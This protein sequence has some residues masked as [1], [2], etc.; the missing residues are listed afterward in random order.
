MELPVRRFVAFAACAAFVCS[1]PKA[2]AQK[3]PDLRSAAS[4]AVLG[5]SVSNTG[6][7]VITGNLAASPGAITGE[8]P[9]VKLG[10]VRNDL[11]AQ[12]QRDLTA[13]HDDLDARSCT[14]T[15]TDLRDRRLSPGVYCLAPGTVLSGPLILDAGGDANAVW[16]FKAG[17]TLATAPD[18]SVRMIDGGNDSN[19]FWQTGSAIVA[20]KTTFVG[21]I[22]A[23]GG[24]TLGDAANVSGRVLARGPVVLSGNFVSLCC[25]RIT[26]LPPAKL[27][28]TVGEE[29]RQKIEATGGVGDFT[30]AVK[31]GPPGMKFVG[32]V[33][34]WTTEPGTVPVTVEATD[35]SGCEGV[36]SFELVIAPCLRIV[37]L[38]PLSPA[39]VCEPYS[40]TF[41]GEC[42]TTPYTCS[43]SGS[44]PGLSFSDCTLSGTPTTKG[45]FPFTVTV[46]DKHASVSQSYALTAGC[47]PPI[48]IAPDTLPNG[49]VGVLYTAVITR[50]AGTL[51]VVDKSKLPPG[52]KATVLDNGDLVVSGVPLNEGGYSFDVTAALCDACASTKSYTITI[53]CPVI[54]LHPS[55]VPATP[56][57]AYPLPPATMDRPY[58][59]TITA[60]TL[61]ATAL[62][63]KFTV[64]GK[65]TW[66]TQLPIDS[67]TL[68]GTP[69][70]RGIYPFTVTA[71]FDGSACSASQAYSIEVICPEITVLPTLP[72]GVVGLPPYNE[73]ISAGGSL[74][75]PYTFVEID[76]P[77]NPSM[78]PPGLTLASDGKVTGMPL[79]PGDY[80]FRVRATDQA[81]CSGDGTVTLHINAVAPGGAI[82]ALSHSAMLVLSLVLAV[83]GFVVI[84]RTH[85]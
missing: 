22:L 43:I 47:P 76:V 57:V 16:I 50:S 42:G 7:T 54:T 56:A 46:T 75:T 48:T 78:L 32:D 41:K 72:S 85:V 79:A 49:L 70:T 29:Y 3:A 83:V 1:A 69:D 31:T 84:R 34:T 5:G 52:L 38:P 13:A 21:N 20:A 14:E 6:P 65:P 80:S 64:T 55:T 19:V 63:L 82:P 71:A 28:G 60:T 53:G 58:S 61:P 24:I 37:P 26:V 33:L 36:V 12:A 81:G 59:T 2:A 8:R 62:P 66:L 23:K 51:M 45:T 68:S 18:S 30:F 11:G 67:G 15:L 44:V 73:T 10:E 9:T 77:P 39:T 17:D 25:V 35:A 40:Q 74:R 27:T 4:F